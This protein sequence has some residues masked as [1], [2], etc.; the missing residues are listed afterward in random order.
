M[1]FVAIDFETA[2]SFVGS[3]CAVGL[4]VM[5]DDTVEESRFWLVK[6]HKSCRYFDPFNISIHGIR[7]SDVAGA[8]EFDALYLKEILPRIAG[9][10]VA[11]HNAAFDM[12]A[13]RHALDLYRIAY[14]DI[15]YLCTYKASVKTWE[16]LD[17]H[18]LDTVSKFLNFSFK[19]HDALEDAL[20]CANILLEVFRKYQTDDLNELL[21]MIGM[22]AGKLL[23]GSYEPC[24]IS[25]SCM[26]AG[27]KRR[28]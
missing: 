1:R 11:A 25:K 12:S 2:N 4:V 18:K 22:R 15:H 26:K 24:S 20:A 6:P 10:V 7:E 16:D 13:M 3:I 28:A 27:G 14:P 23:A 19:H 8:M 21:P 9:S 17:N 5:R